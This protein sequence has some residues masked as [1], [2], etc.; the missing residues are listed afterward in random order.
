[1]GGSLLNIDDFITA[2]TILFFGDVRQKS[3]NRP[4]MPAGTERP[5]QGPCRL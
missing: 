2:Y 1:M 4:F 5:V 3:L